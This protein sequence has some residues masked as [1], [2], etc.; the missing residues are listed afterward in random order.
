MKNVPMLTTEAC[1]SH[2]VGYA[3]VGGAPCVGLGIA[4]GVWINKV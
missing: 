3:E 1:L 2:Q 4:I